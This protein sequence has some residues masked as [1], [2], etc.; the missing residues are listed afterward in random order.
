MNLI[1]GNRLGKVNYSKSAT[2]N[3][4]QYKLHVN[5][6][7][8]DFGLVR[9]IAY[10]TDHKCNIVKEC[11][12]LQYFINASVAGNASKLNFKVRPHGNSKSDRSFQP[13][14]RSTL[15]SIKSSLCGPKKDR[16]SLY[17]KMYR[18]LP[19]CPDYGDGPRDKKT[20]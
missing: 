4:N 12:V 9:F 7:E 14:K 11:I 18:S 3:E 15:D 20:K 13:T 16:D 5:R 19:P 10:F 1:E 2:I 6:R 17:D 8:N